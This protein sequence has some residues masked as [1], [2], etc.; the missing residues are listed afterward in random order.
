MGYMS[1][2]K[3]DCDD[4]QKD[5]LVAALAIGLF[6]TD[7]TLA[8]ETTVDYLEKVILTNI[9]WVTT[10][11]GNITREEIVATGNF[12]DY[13]IDIIMKEYAKHPKGF[14]PNPRCALY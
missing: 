10:E 6:M 11:L 3:I 13:E 8:K 12:S 14:F 2:I 1:G 5:I 9:T 7:K 4:E